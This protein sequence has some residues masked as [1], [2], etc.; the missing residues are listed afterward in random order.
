MGITAP[1]ADYVAQLKDLRL[2]QGEEACAAD[3]LLT[4]H[5]AAVANPN[6]TFLELGTD[7]GQATKVILNALHGS[8]GLLVSIDVEDCSDAGSG[9]NWQFV[10]SSSIDFDAILS[11][12]PRLRDGIDLV[13]IDSL[14]TTAHVHAEFH[15]W[16]PFVKPGG[17]L[18]VDDVDPTPY[19]LGHR[20]DS[21]KKEISNRSIGTLVRET[22]YSNLNALRMDLK[23]GSTGL[24]ILTKTAP[25]GAQLAPYAP[26]TAPRTD[27]ELSDL[28]DAQR[29]H[30]PY[31]NH[32]AD[33]SMLIPLPDNTE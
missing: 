5:D 13:Y 2:S 21:V 17:L 9:P 22:F 4:L 18:L 32:L 20:K 8:D 7:Q 24:A 27:R 14:H 23:L 33:Q 1:Y 19:M 31:K 10:R 16:F 28:H 30:A 29:G 6:G 26:L 15:G 3:Q 11:A 12:A 25:L